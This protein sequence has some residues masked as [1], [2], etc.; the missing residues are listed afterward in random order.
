VARDNASAGHGGAAPSDGTE[1]SSLQLSNSLHGPA[2]TVAFEMVCEGRVSTVQAC[3]GFGALLYALSAQGSITILAGRPQARLSVCCKCTI[4]AGAERGLS[5]ATRLL[6]PP[7]VTTDPYGAVA[8]PL[9]QT[10]T[11]DQISAVEC[12]PY[13]Y[14]RSGNPTRDQLEAHMAALEVRNPASP[15]ICLPC[16]LAFSRQ[17]CAQSSAVTHLLRAVCASSWRMV[18]AYGKTL[19]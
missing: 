14:T 17:G 8:P 7:K 3:I 13:D 16:L 10:A 2:G 19:S 15:S 18:S 12:G 4:Y 9:Y 5:I 6:H 11:F 1:P